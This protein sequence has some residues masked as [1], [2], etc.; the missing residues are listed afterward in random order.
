M[1][2]VQA[3]NLVDFTGGLNLRAD[4]FE[5]G[6][7]ESPDIVNMDIDPR[8]GFFTRKGWERWNSA[9]IAA[10]WD[11]RAMFTHEVASGVDYVFVA[12]N[13]TILQSTNG[14]FEVVQVAAS[15]VVVSAS[16]HLADFAS[17]GDTVYV[18]CGHQQQVLEWQPSST[19]LMTAAGTATFTDYL[20]PSTDVFPQCELVASHAGY[21]FAAYTLEDGVT[22]PHRLRWSHPAVPGAW[23]ADD[24]IDIKEGGGPITAIVP[25]R[26]HLLI[27]KSSSVWALFGYDTGSWQLVNVTREVGVPHRQ[28]VTR[29]EST[30]FFFSWPFGVYA[31][32]DANYPTEVSTQ[33]RPLFES[34][35]FNITKTD[36]IWLGWLK[37]RLWVA[38]PYNK[39]YSGGSSVAP[40]AR[41]IFVFDPTLGRAGAWTAYKGADGSA[42]GPFAQG[43]YGGLIGDNRA[44][45]CAREVAS[46]VRVDELDQAIDNLDGTPVGFLTRYL[47][48]WVDAGWPSLKKQWRSPDMIVEEKDSTYE[49]TISVFRDYD[50]RDPGR[51]RTMTV[52]ASSPGAIW[53]AFNWGEANWGAGG[54]G[55]TIVRGPSFGRA[56][57]IQLLFRGE[58]EKEWGVNGLVLKYIPRRL[59]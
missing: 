51:V 38:V 21:L 57:A 23:N 45:A 52:D 49:L 50:S 26:D 28:A 3:L 18:A 22:H 19:A 11:P 27:F 42:L 17:W 55:T 44:F 4:A 32:T 56:T 34:T 53:G 9:D 15:D 37:N 25:R 8:G 5:L 54:E 14:T 35:E 43:G 1:G 46:V 41:T 59:R 7:N 47:T 48:R 24:Y 39:N 31:I 20:T 13:G 16:P 36:E 2:R 40:T 6:E 58:S 10:T 30:V 29:S 33:L 12:N